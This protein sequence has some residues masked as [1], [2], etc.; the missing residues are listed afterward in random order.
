LTRHIVIV[1][2]SR[3]NADVLSS[4][5]AIRPDTVAHAFT[6]SAE[7]LAFARDNEADAFIVD[8]NMPHP[9]GREMILRLRSDPRFEFV[10]IVILTADG[11]RDNRLAALEAGANDF[12]E[13]P[14]EP[15]E[16]LARLD[17]L[18][19]LHLA[20]QRLAADVAELTGSLRVQEQRS[21]AQA[22]RMIALWRLVSNP[23]LSTEDVMQ[24]ILREGARALR[25]G[26]RFAGTLMREEDD[27]LVLEAIVHGSPSL[28]VLPEIGERMPLAEAVESHLAGGT[29]TVMWNDAQ[30]DAT[31]PESSHVRARDMRAVI[32]TKFEAGRSTYFL[33]FWSLQPLEEPFRQDDAAYVELLG[34]YFSGR[35]Q[36]AW[37]HD[38]ITFQLS[39]DSLTGLRNRTQFRLDAR[40]GMSGGRAGAIAVVSLDGFRHINETYGHMIG[41]ALLVE[42]GAALEVRAQPHDIV[43]RLAGDTFGIFL[44]DVTSGAEARDRLAAYAEAFTHPFGTG[45]RE[46]KEGIP[47]AATIGYDVATDAS[48]HID[49]MLSHADTA[50]FSAKR[51]PRGRG[52][53]VG[54]EPG[55]ESAESARN[56]ML[57]EI[58]LALTR[59]EFELYFQPHIDMK[60]RRVAG[61]EAL[62]RWNHPT[63][64]LISPDE[65]IPF[66]EQ[67]GSIR[68]ISAWVIRETLRFSQSIRALDPALRLYCNLSALDL[69]DLAIAHEFR[70]AK[71]RGFHL[72]NVGIEVTET[73]ATQDIGLML[74]A[75]Q[76]MQDLG[77]RVAI[78]DFGTGYSSL[79]LIKRLPVDVVKIDRTFVSEVLVG[80]YDAAISESVISFGHRFG[81]ETLGEGVETEEQLAWLRD[82]GCGYAQGFL[83]S[84]PLPY[85]DFV[86][87]LGAYRPPSM[88]A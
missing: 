15:A 14:V 34:R 69:T 79:A 67:N 23:D 39:H 76:A 64:Q 55:M 83:I 6:S 33:T 31:P 45:D 78:D 48:S 70:S 8:Y 16:L 17:T 1:D 49:T 73:A 4:I 5:V 72:E 56:R 27:Q 58:A 53:V 87:W 77:V 65:F 30:A 38:R 3:T 60:T 86:R 59:N 54:F 36:Q 20:R 32:A 2:S 50:V 46:G 44:S 28:E 24:A 12:I 82:R 88:V 29:T 80:D 22:D 47:L 84:P 42:V 63:G 10:P 41:D 57:G 19:S 61:A 43:G 71:K 11:A 25:P 81:F 9:D 21:R 18:L 62:I 35:I 37:Q 66:A 13:R 75:V 52:R 68:S 51:T 74:Q 7:A 26:H 85:D 40:A